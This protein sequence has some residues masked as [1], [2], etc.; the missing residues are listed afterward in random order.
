MVI[1]DGAQLLDSN[2]RIGY[3]GGGTNT[4]VI[5]GP[6]SVWKST[7]PGPYSLGI[8]FNT[9]GNS[10]IISNGGTVLSGWSIVNQY[11]NGGNNVVV[12]GTGSLW[13][14]SGK[15]DFGFHGQSNVMVISNGGRVM[16]TTGSLA[17]MGSN[18]TIIVTGFGSVWS[19]SGSVLL[20]LYSAPGNSLI[21]RDGGTVIASNMGGSA[22]NSV[23]LAGGNI[24]VPNGL[25]IASGE[26]LKGSGLIR[27]NSSIYG[28][29][30]P[31]ALTNFGSL[32]L[33]SSAILDIALEGRSQGDRYGFMLVTNGTVT[34]NGLLQVRFTDGFETNV[35]ESDTFTLLTSSSRLTG[36]FTNVLS[37]QRLTTADDDG[38]FLVT[39]NGN[40]L[41]LTDYQAIPEPATLAL[42]LL[43]NLFLAPKSIRRRA[44]F[45]WIHESCRRP[46]C[47]ESFRESESDETPLSCAAIAKLAEGRRDIRQLAG[48]AP[49]N[50]SLRRRPGGR[51]CRFPCRNRCPKGPKKENT[52]SGSSLFLLIKRQSLAEGK[53]LTALRS[54]RQSPSGRR[55]VVGQAVL[56]PG[57]VAG[58]RHVRSDQQFGHLFGRSG[59]HEQ[60]FRVRV[61]LLFSPGDG[62][63]QYGPCQQLRLRAIQNDSAGAIMRMGN[64][65]ATGVGC[66]GNGESIAFVKRGRHEKIGSF[67]QGGFQDACDMA[68]NSTGM[69]RSW[70]ACSRSFFVY[71][72]PFM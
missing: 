66:F 53:T 46:R 23:T 55:E 12:T 13:N 2:G 64:D 4:V 19:N 70:R 1:S 48:I 29:I 60:R 15:L 63:F 22:S 8:G 68:G 26:L 31:V 24:I 44:S 35:L 14:C 20:S 32:T 27:G 65:R 3:N 30:S 16:D 18:N 7:S 5:T 59:H 21:V 11:G 72:S 61:R 54:G 17:E 52:L 40:N 28:T 71:R 43:A 49:Y 36:S 45:R 25:G 33:Q 10:L 9:S 56:A 41:I 69:W 67:Q 34:L 50:S 42:G 37:G 51:R 39:Y 38:S 62:Q 6:G 47:P 58:L 57:R